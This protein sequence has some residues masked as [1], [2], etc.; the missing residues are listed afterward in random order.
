MI[1]LRDVTVAYDSA[2]ALS[3]VSLDIP[4]DRFVTVIGP[5]GCGKTTLLRA[6]GGLV[7]VDDGTISIDGHTTRQAQQKA[8][9]GY[10]FQE[11]TLFPWKTALENI[12]FLRTLAGKPPAIEQA[13]ELL[14]T[15][16]LE[17]AAERHPEELSGGMAQRVAI[18]RALHLEAPVLLMDEPF[19]S[20]DELTRERLS[21]ELRSLWRRRSAT[22]VF[23]T[24]SVPEAVLLGD[25]CL[26]MEGPPGRITHR[27]AIDIEEPRTPSVFETEPFQQ[28]V[29]RIR[30][31]LHGR[32]PGRS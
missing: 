19:G 32:T 17:E 11:Q 13:R 5:S 12:V 4:E 20:L 6:I 21:L 10:V 25:E 16:G 9:L 15:V 24:H 8:L 26:L 30:A 7:P 22:I 14:A 31:A 29:S 3:E 18:A 27:F 28:Q 2:V 1:E 23:V